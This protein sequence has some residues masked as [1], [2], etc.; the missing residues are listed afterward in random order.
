MLI[1]PDSIH[2]LLIFFRPS[3]EKRPWPFQTQFG[4]QKRC[5]DKVLGKTPVNV[6]LC[7]WGVL[8]TLKA[9]VSLEFDIESV[10]V[11]E[12]LCTDC[13]EFNGLSV[14]KSPNHQVLNLHYKKQRFDSF[15]LL[16]F[17]QLTYGFYHQ[18][19]IWWHL[20]DLKTFL[21]LNRYYQ[22]LLEVTYFIT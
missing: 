16:F 8:F 5:Y 4:T 1:F 10:G 13:E 2:P 17:H 19:T 22:G 18:E 14:F 11:N 21:F 20:Q 15:C 7:S 3:R 12:I 9:S 6:T